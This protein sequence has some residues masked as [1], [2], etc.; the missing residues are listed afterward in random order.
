[1]LFVTTVLWFKLIG[2]DINENIFPLS[3][4]NLNKNSVEANQVPVAVF[5][6]NCQANLKLIWK[7]VI[8]ARSQLIGNSFSSE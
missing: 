5:P 4:T 7:N 8:L 6:C 1:M 3:Q 2:Y